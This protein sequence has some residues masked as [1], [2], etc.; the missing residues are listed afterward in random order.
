MEF[1]H[2]EG[3]D[4]GKVVLFALS[5]C[6]WCRKTRKILDSLGVAYSYVYVDM[7]GGDDRDEAVSEMRRHNPAGGFP[8]V[9]IDDVTV[10]SGHSPRRLKEILG[11]NDD[12]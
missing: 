12:R 10:I 11:A 2:V 1:I 6:V 9:V 4:R 7:L 3:A 8:T 5:T